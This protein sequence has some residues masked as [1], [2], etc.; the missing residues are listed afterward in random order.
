MILYIDPGTGSMLFTILIGVLGT[1]LYFLRNVFMKLKYVLSGGKTE[2]AADEKIPY[3]I[4]TDH[5]RYWNVF[6]PICD[7]FEK[8]K[9]PLVYM[10]ESK[11]DPIFG[12]DYRYIEARC[13][14]E[15]NM[16]FAKLNVLNAHVVISTTPSLD[17]FQWKRSKD[18]D[19]Y[20]HI[21][22]MPNDVTT[23]RMFG[24]DYYDAVLVS[25]VYQVEQ[26]R[27][28]EEMRDLPAKDIEI[29]GLPYMDEMKAR[30]D[31][32]NSK[33]E[34]CT[35]EKTESVKNTSE[36][37]I[38]LLAPSWG[39]S[40]ILSKYGERFIDALI[41]T[42][43]KIIIRPH[44]Q[45]FTSEKEM[46]DKLMSKYDDSSRIEWNRDNDNYEVLKKSDIL[47]SDF[48]G[49]IFDF[50]LVFDKSVIFADTSFD[51]APYDAAWLDED[52]WTYRVLPKLGMKLTEDSIDDIKSIIDECIENTRYREGRDI[53]RQET[54]QHIGEGAARAVDFILSH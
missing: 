11:D 7:E 53:A 36:D 22:H 6:E 44:P 52:L 28:L 23:Y 3:V 2:K 39:P 34:N 41:D 9:T 26:I 47:I 31:K 29:V 17:V 1:A 42:G 13:I 43:Y 16:A 45:S 51:K 8:R 30:L 46:L 49:V 10:T 24:L 40:G 19:Y 35:L 14:G 37:K 25:G 33:S 20:I 54:W 5:K 27:K 50:A 38:V 21:T 12:K 18:V 48:S 15:G 4:F 32:D